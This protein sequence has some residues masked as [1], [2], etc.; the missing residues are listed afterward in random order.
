MTDPTKMLIVDFETRS[1]SDL[2]LE[3]ADKYAADQTTEALCMAFAELK[4]DFFGLWTPNAAPS[5]EL[6]EYLQNE[7]CLIGAHNARFDQLIYEYVM[8]SDYG[9]PPIKKDRWYCTSAQARLNGLPANL[10]DATRAIN[11]K[12]KKSH[13]GAYLIKQL[14]VPNKDTGQF[15]TDLGLMREMYDYCEA[16]VQATKELVLNTRRMTA[17]E[18]ADWLANERVNDRGVRIDRE[19]AE[20]CVGYAK[21]EQD[22]IN[23]EL[24]GL[25]KG[26]VTKYTQGQRIKEWLLSKD[27]DLE[28]PM[29]VYKEGVKKLS[30]DKT[31]RGVILDTADAGEL[32]ITNESY[33]VVAALDDGNKSSVAKYRTM[34]QR[35]EYDDRVRGAFIYAGAQTVRFSSR[36][37]QLHNM[38]RDAVSASDTEVIKHQMRLGTPLTDVMTQLAKMMRPTLIPSD[39]NVFVAGD[40]SSIESRAL[41]YLADDKLAD[42]KL[43]AFKRGEDMYLRAAAD[44]GQHGERQLGKVIELSM[45]YGGGVGAFKAMSRNYG[46]H[47]SDPIIDGHKNAWRRANAWAPKFWNNL[48]KSARFAIRNPETKAPVSRGIT[49]LFAPRLMGGS[50]ICELPDG[51]CLT[52]PQ[53]R[54]EGGEITAMK[55]AYG[56]K[57]DATEWPR[58][59]LWGGLLSE[60]VTQAF[61]AALLRDV[62]L[63]MPNA[64]MHVH[65]E[66]VLESPSAEASECAKRLQLVME[67]PPAWAIG[68][69]LQ[70][71]PE[72]LTRYGKG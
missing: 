1:S 19:L 70:A 69:P 10:D 36:G 49:Y 7:N 67:T 48:E 33:D 4:G 52:Y 41:A 12:H 64:V 53:A 55:A 13:R 62:L 24:S 68:L 29:T 17:R 46:I 65:D 21:V 5:P 71:E 11:A 37:L 6:I 63:D 2:K 44:I 31:I 35:A 72:I 8:V 57:Q 28:K 40:W 34:L 23:L 51:T 58:Y 14:C 39:G 38:R 50:L 66:V 30:L 43:E 18:H 25:T 56:M 16:D 27:P 54:I 59:K 47:L 22:A 3:G 9:F 15:N 45:G 32:R 60:N 42:D 61:C 26:A 20:L